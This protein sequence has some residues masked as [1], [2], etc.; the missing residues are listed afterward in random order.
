M[1]NARPTHRCRNRRPRCLK[2]PTFIRPENTLGNSHHIRDTTSLITAV[3]YFHPSTTSAASV[4]RTVAILPETNGRV[5]ETFVD[6]DQA[7]EQGQPIF[8]LDDVEQRA[9]LET[10]RRRLE[11]ID[12]R[13]QILQAQ[14]REAEERIVQARGQL[15]QA[16]DEFN[17]RSELL[18]N[19]SSAIPAR[20][21]QRARVLA[22][23]QEGLVDAAIA[24]RDALS[25]QIQF[26]LPAQKASAEAALHQAQVELDKTLVVAGTDGVVQKSALRPGDMVNPILRPAGI[27]VPAR[28]V[29]ALAAGF[30]RVEA[31]VMKVGMTGEVACTAMP[32]Q[33]VPVVVTEAQGVIASGKIRPTDQLVELQQVSPGG[34]ITVMMEPLFEGALDGLPQGASCIANAYISNHDRLEDPDLGGGS[35][36]RFMPS[37]RWCWF[38]PS[39]C[40]SRRCCSPFG[41]WS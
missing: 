31:R 5:A 34:S 16:V 10:A 41:P 19:Q 25:A 39:S 37:T 36:S 29:T 17:V 8:R 11:E 2:Q 1:G 15:A 18:Q 13:M 4:F 40:A 23:T 14:L 9:E 32:W 12:A 38:T 3:V 28:R 30:G 35:A 33:I 24:A 6:I 27:L 7:V 20:E 26:Q 21:V 22:E